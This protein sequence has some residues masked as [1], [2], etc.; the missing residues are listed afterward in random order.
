MVLQDFRLSPYR[1]GEQN[2]GLVRLRRRA[3][4][5]VISVNV[6]Q[7]E[8]IDLHKLLNKRPYSVWF[9]R[10]LDDATMRDACPTLPDKI[11]VAEYQN[12]VSGQPSSQLP[13]AM[14]MIMSS[15]TER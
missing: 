12:T 6:L 3:A 4:A 15:G 2:H 8:I 11:P 13:R 7:F 14:M 10:G 5:A 9:D 1:I